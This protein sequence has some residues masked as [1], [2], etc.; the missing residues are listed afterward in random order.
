MQNVVQDYAKEISNLKAKLTEQ[1]A[2]ILL[3]Q[4]DRI[5][6]KNPTFGYPKLGKILSLAKHLYQNCQKF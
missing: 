2:T 6:V 5:S 4:E 1:G 3:N